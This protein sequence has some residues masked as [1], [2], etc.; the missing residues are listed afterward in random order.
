MPVPLLNFPLASI[1]DGLLSYIQWVFGNPELTPPEYRWN[2]DDRA[3]RI[4]IGAPFVIDNSKPMSAPFIVVER[5]PFAFANNT[6]NNLRSASANTLEEP[7][8]TDWMD[9]GVNIICGSGVASEASSIANFIAIMIQADRH[10]IMNSLRFLRN[11]NYASVGPEIPVVKDSEVRRWEVTLLVSTSLQIGWIKKVHGEPIPWTKAGFYGT[12]MPSEDFSV[13]G[14]LSEGSDL[15]IDMTKDFG[16]LNTNDPQLLQQEFEKGWY[17]IRLKDNEFKQ[18][19]KIVDIV[20]NHTI[21][22]TTHDVD[23]E[24]VPYSAPESA[25][26]VGYDLYWN[27]IHLRM[28]IPGK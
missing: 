23:G 20:D 8:F 22:L 10:G 19:Y 12:K 1:V 16:F 9:G 6:L 14:V 5:T 11:M 2:S 27:S 25:I 4:R 26:N 24:E 28:E 13:S 15:L 21:Q 18:L 3:S 7:A 17:Y